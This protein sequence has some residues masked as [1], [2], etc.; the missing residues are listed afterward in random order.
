MARIG[1]D[2]VHDASAADDLAMLTNTFDAGANFHELPHTMRLPGKVFQYTPR[3]ANL[4]R[5]LGKNFAIGPICAATFAIFASD[6]HLPLRKDGN[7][8]DEARCTCGTALASI[9]LT[10]ALSRRERGTFDRLF[11]KSSPS[12]PAH[13]LSPFG[14]AVSTCGPPP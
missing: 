6:P 5:P 14:P 11:E 12:N 2:D 3:E 4:A 1:A 7:N 9:S 10:L 13:Q 8:A